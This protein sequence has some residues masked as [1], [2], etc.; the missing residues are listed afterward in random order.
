MKSIGSVLPSKRGKSSFWN[1][2]GLSRS[3]GGYSRPPPPLSDEDDL[4]FMV[5]KSVFTEDSSVWN[6]FIISMRSLMVGSAMVVEWPVEA[7]DT[8]GDGG[9][10]E[11]VEEDRR[12]TDT[13]LSSASAPNDAGPRLR[14]S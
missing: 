6:D 4:S 10:L 11:R 14:N 3:R 12:D 9:G 5:A 7:V 8:E 2:G 1:F 13:R